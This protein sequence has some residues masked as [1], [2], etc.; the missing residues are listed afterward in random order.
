MNQ[1]FTKSKLLGFN[2]DASGSKAPEE[3][4]GQA[5][6][7]AL[8]YQRLE[9]LVFLE[10]IRR[11]YTVSI[12]KINNLEIDFIATKPTEK[13]YVQV[14]ASVQSEATRQREFLPLEKLTDNYPKYVVTMDTTIYNDY[15]GIK[16]MNIVDFLLNTNN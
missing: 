11:G 6:Y 9:N 12:G 13:I 2:P 15:N 8:S 14:S 3:K 4:S 10:L 1:S 16:I 7:L 5:L